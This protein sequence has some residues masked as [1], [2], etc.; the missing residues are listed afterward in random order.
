M[1]YDIKYGEV[2]A[3]WGDSLHGESG[4]PLNES[5]EPV[6]ILRAQEVTSVHALGAYKKLLK[7]RGASSERISE[8]NDVILAFSQWQHENIGRVKAASESSEKK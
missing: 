6:F 3:R 1:A 2:T 5:D 4:I 7:E 8:V